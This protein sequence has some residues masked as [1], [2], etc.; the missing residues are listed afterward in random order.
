MIVESL[1]LTAIL[2]FM[3][4]GHGSGHG[5]I[6]DDPDPWPNSFQSCFIDQPREILTL[7]IPFHMQY[8]C[9]KSDPETENSGKQTCRFWLVLMLKW[10]TWNLETFDLILK[11]QKGKKKREK[12]KN[13]PSSVICLQSTI[14]P[15]FCSSKLEGRPLCCRLS[16]KVCSWYTVLLYFAR[17]VVI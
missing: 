6:L 16:D 2:T 7:F 11:K 10:K 3:S 9:Q 13:F 8:A 5:L 15:T 14:Y 1:V 12:E 4:L 17:L